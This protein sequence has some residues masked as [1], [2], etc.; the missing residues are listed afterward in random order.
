M[1]DDSF[2]GLTVD[3]QLAVLGGLGLALVAVSYQIG[4]SVD[5]SYDPTV[6]GIGVVCLLYAALRFGYERLG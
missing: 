2:V 6:F 5:S 3:Q 4:S 1:G